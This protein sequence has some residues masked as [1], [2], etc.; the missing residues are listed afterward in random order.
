MHYSH[1]TT[2]ELID[3]VGQVKRQIKML[4]NKKHWISSAEKIMLKSERAILRELEKEIDKRIVQ[5]PF[6]GGGF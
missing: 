1:M 3:R 5:L 6:K 4:E 2:D